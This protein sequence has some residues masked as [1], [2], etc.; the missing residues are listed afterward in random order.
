MTAES[1]VRR[2]V[3]ELDEKS[4]Y[5]IRYGKEQRGQIEFA[6][7]MA[8]HFPT[9]SATRIGCFQRSNEAVAA[10]FANEQ[11]V[12]A[13][14]KSYEMMPVDSIVII[15][16]WLT[17]MLSNPIDDSKD[18][19]AASCFLF[20][21]RSTIELVPTIEFYCG[22]LCACWLTTEKTGMPRLVPLL[23]ESISKTVRQRLLSNRAH[24]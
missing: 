12:Q 24:F 21:S 18:V 23:Y 1:I 10:T 17:K 9:P 7:Q 14:R 19:H 15:E 3:E 4:E 13:W 5:S 20:A 16:R 2:F 22:M 6:Q 8:A 11:C